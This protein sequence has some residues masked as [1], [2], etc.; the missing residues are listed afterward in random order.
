MPEQRHYF[1]VNCE[2]IYF[3]AF[4]SVSIIDFEQVNVSWVLLEFFIVNP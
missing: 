1:I 3:K 2:H 4:S